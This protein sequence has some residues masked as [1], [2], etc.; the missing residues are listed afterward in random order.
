MEMWTK[1]WVKKGI[2]AV[3]VKGEDR[4]PGKE[5]D[6][7]R[8]F[9]QVYL[10]TMDL[11]EAAKAVGETP[12]PELLKRY[13]GEVE[14]WRDSLRQQVT[15]ED[16]IRRLVRLGFGSGKEC[17]SLLEGGGAEMDLSLVSEVKRSANGAVE[18][19]L[20]D[21]VGVLRQLL[22]LL[23]SDEDGAEAFLRSLQGGEAGEEA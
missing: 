14:R 9:A 19:K 17:I 13:E 12:R 21:R 23:K 4:M 20:I 11:E 15:Q 6:R 3:R 18:F 8:T 16:V 7:R 22:E 10:K 5:T 1:E 2:G